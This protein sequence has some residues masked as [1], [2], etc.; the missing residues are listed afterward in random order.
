M[1][2][3]PLNFS[4]NLFSSFLQNPELQSLIIEKNSLKFIEPNFGL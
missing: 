1:K 4:R 2:V 3:R